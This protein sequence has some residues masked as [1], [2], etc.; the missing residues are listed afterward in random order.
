MSKHILRG[1][2]TTSAFV[3]QIDKLPQ[4]GKDDLI[5]RVSGRAR[6][7]LAELR[8]QAREQ[9]KSEGYMV[10]FGDGQQAGY[11]DGYAKGRV[12]AREEHSAQLAQEFEATRSALERIVREAEISVKQWAETA[13]AE[14]TDSVTDI[15]R[16]ALAEE[17]SLSRDSILAIVRRALNEVIGGTEVQLHVNPV[18]MGLVEAR[19]NDLLQ[20]T[21]SIQGLVVRPNRS[22]EAGCRLETQ[23][24]II[25]ATVE[26]YLERIDNHLEDAA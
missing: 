4:F 24:G 1:G 7:E 18:D 17:L 22:I 21:G 8:E 10:G 3:D 9:G 2:V 16:E 14:L 15:A 11:R 26:G 25:D 23:A 13:E 19:L 5:R 12:E 6:T 20:A